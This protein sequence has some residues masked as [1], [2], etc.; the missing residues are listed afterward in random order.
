MLSGPWGTCG[1]DISPNRHCRG[2]SG[3][4]L[5]GGDKVKSGIP[6]PS[7]GHRPNQ[8]GHRVTAKGIVI[9]APGPMEHLE[10]V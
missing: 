5:A 1:V 4:A 6:P 9:F 7:T 2:L 3:G 8:H 10:Q